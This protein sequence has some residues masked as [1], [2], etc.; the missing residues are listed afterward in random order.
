MSLVYNKR[1]EP[2]TYIIIGLCKQVSLKYKRRSVLHWLA[3]CAWLLQTYRSHAQCSC[4]A[5]SHRQHGNEK[6]LVFSRFA[7]RNGSWVF[8]SFDYLALRLAPVCISSKHKRNNELYISIFTSRLR[9]YDAIHIASIGSVRMECEPTLATNMC[10]VI[11]RL[12]SMHSNSNKANRICVSARFVRT[13]NHS[14]R[15]A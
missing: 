13:W 15:F 9:H 10:D 14:F 6:S 7:N 2:H 4:I 1:S 3:V 5:L 11:P 12:R 8:Q